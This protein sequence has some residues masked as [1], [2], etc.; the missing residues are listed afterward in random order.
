MAAEVI[1]FND[2]VLST[3]SPAAEN[4]RGSGQMDASIRNVRAHPHSLSPV[5]AEPAGS[6]AQVG[7]DVQRPAVS[8]CRKLHVVGR[9]LQLCL[10]I[11]LLQGAKTE[12]H[13]GAAV[14]RQPGTLPLGHLQE[15]RKGCEE[16][17]R[18]GLC[19]APSCPAPGAAEPN[20]LQCHWEP[21]LCPAAA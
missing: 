19:C 5:S 1:S 3:P 15:E 7:K 21:G 2:V 12:S 16:R 8:R 4:T 14:S 20:L 11:V 13:V 6:S 18:L 17:R 10:Q 9:L